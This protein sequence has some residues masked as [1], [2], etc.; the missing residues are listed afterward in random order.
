MAEKFCVIEPQKV[1]Y[2]NLI[3][4]SRG[5]EKAQFCKAIELMVLEMELT[6]SLTVLSKWTIFSL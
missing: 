5:R 4:W 1:Y 3:D 6:C 2:Y